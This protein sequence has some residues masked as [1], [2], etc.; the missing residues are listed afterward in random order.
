MR[1]AATSD[2]CGHLENMKK[3]RQDVEVGLTSTIMIHVLV[4][5]HLSSNIESRSTISP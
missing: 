4:R 5:I 1:I 2:L 3:G